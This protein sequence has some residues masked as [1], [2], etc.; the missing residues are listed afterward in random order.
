MTSNRLSPLLVFLL[1]LKQ[2]ISCLFYVVVSKLLSLLN[3]LFCFLIGFLILIS[4]QEVRFSYIYVHGGVK[5]A[6]YRNG[7][8]FDFYNPNYFYFTF[9]LSFY[10]T[11]FV[12]LLNSLFTF[13]SPFLLSDTDNFYYSPLSPERS[14]LMKFFPVIA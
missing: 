5:E 2:F 1:L 13:S 9:L 8:K 11:I 3:I 14:K 6:C 12:F 7:L 4:F 10:F